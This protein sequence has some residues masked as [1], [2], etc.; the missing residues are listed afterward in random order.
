MNIFDRVNA[1]VRALCEVGALT[2]E[3]RDK[4]LAYISSDAAGELLYELEES[5]CS[6]EDVVELFTF[7]AGVH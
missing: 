3:Q 6:T 5:G 7:A 2:V 4:I 1:D